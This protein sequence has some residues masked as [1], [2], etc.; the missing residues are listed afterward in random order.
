M[1]KY[2]H[3]LL[4]LLFNDMFMFNVH[5]HS[6]RQMKKLK[7]PRGRTVAVYKSLRF[8]GFTL[9][10]KLPDSQ[11][12]LTSYNVFKTRVKKYILNNGFS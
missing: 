1:L 10:N 6:T 3:S 11:R 2:Y 8:R 12:M 5:V 9:W 4:P 7:V